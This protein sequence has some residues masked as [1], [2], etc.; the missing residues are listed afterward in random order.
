VVAGEIAIQ[1]MAVEPIS[2]GTPM[3]LL[4]SDEVQQAQVVSQ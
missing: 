1:Q 2:T 3:H 4:I